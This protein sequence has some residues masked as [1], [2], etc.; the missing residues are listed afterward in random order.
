MRFILRSKGK[1]GRDLM[2]KTAAIIEAAGSSWTPQIEKGC[3]FAVIFGGDGTLMRDQSLL[4]CPVLGVNP[5]KS[6]GYYM[7]AGRSDFEGKIKK[8]IR[9]KAGRD[10]HVHSLLR[11]SAS[12]NGKTIPALALNDVLVSPIYVRRVLKATLSVGKAKSTERNSGI[13]VYTPTGSHAFAH[14]AGAGRLPYDS[15][16]MGV[17]AFAPYSGKLKKSEILV[18]RGPV[19]V[20]CLGEEAEVCI[21]GSEVNLARITAGDVVKVQRSGRPLRLVG[22]SK[23]FDA[24]K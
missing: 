8:L 13:I 12:V 20:E 3:D 22:F 17:A 18:A 19:K 11:L 1:Y 24:K 21:D 5:G 14:S 7:K 16:M 4:S 23:R 10:Y 15:S 6:V 9:G 2:E